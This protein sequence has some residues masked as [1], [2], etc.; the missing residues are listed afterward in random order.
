MD[1]GF[2]DIC[3]SLLVLAGRPRIIPKIAYTYVR[4]IALRNMRL[5]RI[6]ASCLMHLI[7]PP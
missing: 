1:V 4:L 6:R 3:R 7:D 5:L 2:Y